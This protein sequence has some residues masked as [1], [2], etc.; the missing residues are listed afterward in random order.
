MRIKIDRPVIVEGK[1]DKIKLQSV[2]DATIITT[3]G[4][5]LFNRKEKLA[6]IRR[7]AEKAGVIVLTDSDGAGKVIRNFI[8]SALPKDKVIHLYIPE[9]A[10]K[11]RR[12]SAPSKAGTLGVEGMEADL[13]HA[14]FAPFASEGDRPRGRPVTKTDFFETGLSGH[15]DSS[16]LR[17]ALAMAFGL[18]SK[19][20]ANAL[21]AA[22]NIIAD[23]DG[24]QKTLAEI[25]EKDFKNS[26]EKPDSPNQATD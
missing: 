21:L 3:D 20:T 6:L 1:Y 23:Y 9:I 7:L 10:G 18:P 8:S 13:L 12:K 24:F 15:Q 19:M 2:I 16:R 11:E 22:L 14:L 4:F 17:D 5:S 25:K 26:D